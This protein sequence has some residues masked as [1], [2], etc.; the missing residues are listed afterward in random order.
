MDRPEPSDQYS[1]FISALAGELLA[2]PDEDTAHHHVARAAAAVQTAGSGWR[3]EG[4]RWVA[5]ATAFITL[6][7]TGGVA[8]A[9]GLPEPIQVVIA[10]SARALPIPVAIPYPSSSSPQRLVFDRPAA[11]Q[12]EPG[13]LDVSGQQQSHPGAEEAEAN[14]VSA[15]P[16]FDVAES[17]SDSTGEERE[18]DNRCERVSADRDTRNEADCDFASFDDEERD[19][20]RNDGS[21]RIDDRESRGDGDREASWRSDREHR[22]DRGDSGSDR[23]EDRHDHNSSDDSSSDG[24]RRDDR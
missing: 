21:E 16:R 10:D 17:E 14:D 12:T 19:H 15:S 24:G 8:A 18:R 1:A 20:S 4:L 11:E 7:G 23:Q 22:D 13:L 5:A 2:V 9:G 3:P 6:I